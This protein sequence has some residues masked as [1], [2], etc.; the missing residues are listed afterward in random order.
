MQPDILSDTEEGH[1]FG[2]LGRPLPRSAME[3]WKWYTDWRMPWRTPAQQR[4]TECARQPMI[5]QCLVEVDP[6]TRQERRRAIP[7]VRTPSPSH[8]SNDYDRLLDTRVLSPNNKAV[9]FFDWDRE[10]IERENAF[11]PPLEAASPELS[12][13]PEEGSLSA[14]IRPSLVDRPHNPWPPGRGH[15]SA[16]E[17]RQGEISPLAGLSQEQRQN[18]LPRFRILPLRQQLEV[19]RRAGRTSNWVQALNDVEIQYKRSQLAPTQREIYDR[20]K[21]LQASAKELLKGIK[22]DSEEI[23]HDFWISIIGEL[24]AD[25]SVEV[26]SLLGI[27]HRAGEEA[28]LGLNNNGVEIR[29]QQFWLAVLQLV[30]DKGVPT[31][32]RQ[33]VAQKLLHCKR[34]DFMTCLTEDIDDWLGG[35]GDRGKELRGIYKRGDFWR[36]VLKQ[37]EE[38]LETAQTT[39]CI[40]EDEEAGCMS[41]EVLRDLMEAKIPVQ[42]RAWDSSAW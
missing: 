9:A 7:R 22:V 5:Q 30:D 20:V 37:W 33:H 36:S 3:D 42:M 41:I 31:E 25:S 17:V 40:V 27:F 34:E 4:R 2:T 19:S 21:A 6:A 39:Y 38:W 12:P 8:A 15:Y 10:E 32:L 29:R 24:P 1:G 18:V 13:V 11:T 26:E 16:S 23:K 28:G 35:V 14:M